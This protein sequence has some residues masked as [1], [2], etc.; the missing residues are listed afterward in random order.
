MNFAATL[1]QDQAIKAKGVKPKEK[2]I[3][4]SDRPIGEFEKATQ[5]KNRPKMTQRQ[6]ILHLVLRRQHKRGKRATMTQRHLAQQW[7][8]IL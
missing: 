6:L 2:A 1:Q 3:R 5:K 8:E 4:G 7:N